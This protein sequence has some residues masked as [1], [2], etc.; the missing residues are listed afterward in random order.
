MA[1]WLSAFSH[2]AQEETFVKRKPLNRLLTAE[3]Y[4]GGR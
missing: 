4:F 3:G 1:Y 2:Q